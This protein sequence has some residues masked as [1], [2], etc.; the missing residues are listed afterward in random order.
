MPREVPGF[1]FRNVVPVCGIYLGQQTEQQGKKGGTS[2]VP[3]FERPSRK[4]MAHVLRA[5]V[6]EV[7][8][9]PGVSP[10][11]KRNKFDYIPENGWV[12]ETNASMRTAIHVETENT[13]KLLYT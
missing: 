8:G 13:T 12:Q 5:F 11:W 3:N 6:L 4:D 7:C 9:P 1:H 10:A 2:T